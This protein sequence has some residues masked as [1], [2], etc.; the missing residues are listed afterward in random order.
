HPAIRPGG[1]E[2]YALDLY[3]ALRESADFEP[4]FLARAGPPFGEP[5]GYHGPSPFTMVGND[6][7]QYLFYTNTFADHS[8]WDP[9]F[10]KWANKQI[11]SRFFRDFL[12]AQ[13][14]DIVHFQHFAHLGYE[15]V[16]VAR[17][18]LPGVPLVCSL[19]EYLAICHRD[20]QMVRTKGNE[21]CQ[22]ESPRRC[23]ECFPE[24]SP[25]TFFTR[26]RFIQSHLNLADLFVVPSEYA[27]E[28]YSEWGI[29]RS[30]IVVKPYSRQ[31]LSAEAEQFAPEQPNGVRNR[32]AFFGQL[33]PYKGADVLLEAMEI[34]GHDFNGEL[35]VFGANLEIQPPEFRERVQ[36]LMNGKSQITFQGQ[37]DRA[38][39]PKLMAGID[40][41]VVPS[42]W[43]E[44][45]PIVV[46]E[47]F[48]H[49]RPVI[50]SDIGGMSEKVT[51][52]LNGLHFRT[53]DP[54]DLAET[55]RRAAETPGLWEELQAGVPREPGH[56]IDED[57]EIMTAIYKG[58]LERRESMSP[59]L[60]L[61]EAA[62]G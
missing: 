58:L 44:T 41:V 10:G 45:G 55:M 48:Q 27:A 6:P 53:G 23:H 28:R 47:A 51:D 34:L 5:T 2:L 39:L 43:W 62:H 12:L 20:G 52:G 36:T 60:S 57:V 11:L 13:K 54:H 16:R 50:C 46:W 31:P 7:N 19:H 30:K 1:M 49:G 38:E 25:H 26:K 21:L 35:L 9:L 59:E 22:N 15:I 33:N 42:I 3:E 32:F 8:S 40:W 37:Y 29:P 14:P 61:E 24:I 17:N 18:T 4:I 56:S